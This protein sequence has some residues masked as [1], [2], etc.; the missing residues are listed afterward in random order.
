[1]AVSNGA[2]LKEYK[3]I[4]LQ[5]QEMSTEKARIFGRQLKAARGL[6]TL[7]QS[8]LAESVGLTRPHL[9][10]I[11]AGKVLPHSGTATKL[12][13]AI[14]ARGVEFTNGDNP[15]VRLKGAK[16]VVPT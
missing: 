10:K 2:A 1:M 12:R 4:L 5:A 11:E 8:E 15:G 14:E 6:L 13:E 7:S 16:E 3:C 9:A